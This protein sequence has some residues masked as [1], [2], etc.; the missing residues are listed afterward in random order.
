MLVR[1]E[2]L[3]NTVKLNQITRKM[4]HVESDV[5]LIA[6][7]PPTGKNTRR[8]ASTECASRDIR[9]IVSSPSASHALP[10][11]PLSVNL[12]LND[13]PKTAHADI[14]LDEISLQTKVEEKGTL[15][16]QQQWVKRWIGNLMYM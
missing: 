4:D 15:E 6:T 5:K 7:L 16:L 10:P 12:H 13:I 14:A 11:R 9:N 8:S 2:V 1:G 3:Q